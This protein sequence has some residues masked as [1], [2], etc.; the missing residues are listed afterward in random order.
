M[1]ALIIEDEIPAAIRLEKLL[2]LKGFTIL[3][4]LQSVKNA[5]LWFK[6]NN[7]PEL[8][9][10][11]VKLRD[12][13]CFEILDSVKIN[14]KI[15]FTT[16]YDEFALNAF[17]YNSIAY[18]LKPLN[19]IKLDTLITKIDTLKI[20]FHN[21]VENFVFDESIKQVYKNHFL[22]TVGNSLKKINSADIVFIFS[23][24][25]A[26]YIHTNDNRTYLIHFSLD[27]LEEELCPN[28]FFRINRKFILSKKNITSVNIK[29][30]E[31]I[32]LNSNSFNFIVS[33]LKFK[34]FLEWNK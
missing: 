7:H 6:E 12:G 1:T 9:F 10:I 11:D 22:V 14:S 2:I 33:K 30:K 15:V 28:S 23:E 24:N 4:T 18:L 5:I 16:A 27:K 8:V 17:N 29:N 34:S 26:S 20:G 31:I 21:N 3:I 13:N 19:E 25:N 32:I